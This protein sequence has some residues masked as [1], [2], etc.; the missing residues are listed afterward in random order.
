MIKGLS[1]YVGNSIFGYRLRLLEVERSPFMEEV[2]PDAS[3]YIVREVDGNSKNDVR[4]S[5]KY[6]K[7]VIRKDKNYI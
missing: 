5:R 1:C 6:R 3:K 2:K 4:C 7:K